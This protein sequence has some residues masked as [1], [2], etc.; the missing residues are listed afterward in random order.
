MRLLALFAICLLALFVLPSSAQE[1]F[2]PCPFIFRQVCGSDGN[3]Y[4]NE[5]QLNCEIK[6]VGRQGRNL[7]KSR[8]GPC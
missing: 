6:R 3:T 5:C 4:S 8:D 2:C 1:G 7:F